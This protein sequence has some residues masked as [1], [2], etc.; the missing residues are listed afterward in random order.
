M[1]KYGISA[2]LNSP[3]TT[4]LGRTQALQRVGDD[5]LGHRAVERSPAGESS[6]GRVDAPGGSPPGEAETTTMVT[7]A[8][9]SM[10]IPWIMEN[11]KGQWMIN[12]C[13]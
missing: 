13:P 8:R 9:G 12:G 4:R 2:Q 11:P 6:L 3:I 10:V 5:P 1:D 7:M